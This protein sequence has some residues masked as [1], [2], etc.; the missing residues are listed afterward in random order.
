MVGSATPPSQPSEQMS[1]QAQN[2]L[3]M[4]MLMSRMQQ[5]S[6]GLSSEQM[7]PARS[8]RAA[9]VAVHVGTAPLTCGM[10]DG[11]NDWNKGGVSSYAQH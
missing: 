9:R 1:L 5:Y 7:R 10:R 4:Q 3:L 6:S 8:G 2:D 11:T